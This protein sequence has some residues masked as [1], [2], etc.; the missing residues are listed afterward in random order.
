MGRLRWAEGRLE[1]GLNGERL[2]RWA[3]GQ[4]PTR[5]A[6]TRQLQISLKPSTSFIRTRRTTSAPWFTAPGV[7]MWQAISQ[8]LRRRACLQRGRRPAKWNA[9]K[10][11]PGI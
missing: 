7:R 11:N 6:K 3:H 1:R 5:L 4:K 2:H 10:P 8:V 9:E